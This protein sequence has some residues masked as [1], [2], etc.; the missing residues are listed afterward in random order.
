VA[1]IPLLLSL[2]SDPA[3][4]HLETGTTPLIYAAR[5]GEMAAVEVL[6]DALGKDT[7][8][9]V[10]DSHGSTAL[11]V[12]AITCNA[13]VAARLIG[14]G[15]SVLR[16][17]L[18][19]N[20]AMHV[21]AWYCK[22]KEEESARAFATV[23]M[24]GLAGEGGMGSLDVFGGTKRSALMLAAMR[25]NKGFVDV[26]VEHGASLTLRGDNADNKSAQELSNDA[27]L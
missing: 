13:G 5:N 17:D 11:N 6:L 2:G 26:L 19:G 8:V 20:N 21:G 24:E 10:A 12:V 22:E 18:A 25:G 16:K 27:E 15:A 4:G 14:A 7:D 1:S 3:L 9:D 23:L